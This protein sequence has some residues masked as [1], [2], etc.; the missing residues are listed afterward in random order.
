M[1]WNY[2][3]LQTTLFRELLKDND[4]VAAKR[5]FS[6]LENI[7]K[8]VAGDRRKE[9]IFYGLHLNANLPIYCRFVH[10]T[11]IYYYS[12]VAQKSF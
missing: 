8:K 4:S 9:R 2:P 12:R 5:P 3:F 6:F 7:K 11:L 10:K 1:S